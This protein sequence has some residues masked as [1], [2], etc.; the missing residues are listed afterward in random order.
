M[1]KLKLI[2][3]AIL[4]IVVTFLQSSS[5]AT[6]LGQ[7]ESLKSQF[8]P[9]EYRNTN[10]TLD[11]IKKVYREKCKKV[12]GIDNS[13]LYHDIE[14]G[15]ASLSACVSGFTNFSAIQEEIAK[16][17]P[18]GELDS[19]FH[20]YCT[21]IPTIMECV[22]KFNLKV[23][24]CLSPEE[25]NQNAVMMRVAKSL[26]KFMC[27]RGGDQIALFVAED[28]PECIE[29]NKEAIT[30]CMNNSFSQYMPKD[31]SIPD[32]NDL[33]ELVFQPKQCV[34]L[35][36]FEK[37]TIHHLEQCQEVTPANI[38]ESIFKFIKNETSCQSWIDA[39]ANER[40]VLRD[41][42]SNGTLELSYNLLYILICSLW[43]LVHRR[44]FL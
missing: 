43:I 8:L 37:C 17:T 25:K 28:G 4:A 32:I 33:P 29:A 21:K 24:P 12:S 38:A 39:K 5:Q 13:T 41:P 3:V 10:F 11:D 36:R 16:A 27:D 14:K 26:L 30:N 40:S 44:Y 2:L 1:Y 7:I 22:Q 31:G 15:A 18:I 34:D 9:K 6:S 42:K 19:V 20:N 23:Q 35:E